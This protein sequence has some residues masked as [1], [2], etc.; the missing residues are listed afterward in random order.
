[1]HAESL[2]GRL[3]IAVPGLGIMLEANVR[4]HFQTLSTRPPLYA[5]WPNSRW[6]KALGVRRLRSH[7][8]PVTASSG[9]SL[10]DESYYTFAIGY[11]NPATGEARSPSRRSP[12]TSQTWR[13]TRR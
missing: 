10:T 1:M 4:N 12:S 5:S 13:P 9:G 8:I 3:L 11:Y 2:N 6:T 7:G